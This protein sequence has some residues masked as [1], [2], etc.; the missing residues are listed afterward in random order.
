M[1]LGGARVPNSMP[2]EYPEN[3]NPNETGP[4]REELGEE[5]IKLEK[6]RE[7]LTGMKKI[8]AKQAQLTEAVF[9]HNEHFREKG[10]KTN[11]THLEKHKAN[12][13]KEEKELT[14]VNKQLSDIATTLASLGTEYKETERDIELIIKDSHRHFETKEELTDFGFRSKKISAKSF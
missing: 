4:T 11:P 5:Y 9:R 6:Q 7:V 1:P 13:D 8:L 12:I 14:L 2:Q 3:F 10:D